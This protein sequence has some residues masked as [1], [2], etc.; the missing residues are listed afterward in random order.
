MANFLKKNLVLILCGIV[1]LG[2]LGA[3]IWFLVNQE[4]PEDPGTSESTE[5]LGVDLDT[6]LGFGEVDMGSGVV[7]VPS[8]GDDSGSVTPVTP[9]SG[10]SDTG[11]SD[12]GDSN[13]GNSNTGD[14]NTGDSNTGDSNTG[15]GSQTVDMSGGVVDNPFN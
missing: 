13:T 3:G 11:N 12:T 6:D 15:N 9:D 4:Q 1:V 2:A 14:S 10:N 8:N 5:D 7:N